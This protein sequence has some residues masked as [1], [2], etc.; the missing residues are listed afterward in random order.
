MI[1]LT[2]EVVKTPCTLLSLIGLRGPRSGSGTYPFSRI[3]WEKAKTSAMLATFPYPVK[4]FV[5]LRNDAPG[6]LSILTQLAWFGVRD[7]FQT[8]VILQIHIEGLII[9]F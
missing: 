2:F 6:S 8:V 5:T 7:G 4:W 3:G 1:S 9:E